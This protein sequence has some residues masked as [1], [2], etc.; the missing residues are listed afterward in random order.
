MKTL[1]LT[2][3]AL[4]T[5]SATLHVANAFSNTV[6]ECKGVFPPGSQEF[7]CGK[8]IHK[9]VHSLYYC[10]DFKGSKYIEEFPACLTHCEAT[11]EPYCQGGDPPGWAITKHVG[12][13]CGSHILEFPPPET[14]TWGS[15]RTD[16]KSEVCHHKVLGRTNPNL[17]TYIH[18]VNE[19]PSYETLSNYISE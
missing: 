13:F 16:A 15:A 6:D 5:L 17:A 2:L 14:R 12:K 18:K 3:A 7:Y 10:F 1:T 11:S 8:S 9:D 19:N 4:A